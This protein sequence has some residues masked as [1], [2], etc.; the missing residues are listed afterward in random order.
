MVSSNHNM[1]Y[2]KRKPRHNHQVRFAHTRPSPNETGDDDD[3]D[4]DIKPPNRSKNRHRPK[5]GSSTTSTTTPTITTPL[6]I[7]PFKPPGTFLSRSRRK[8]NPPPHPP[9]E[10]ESETPPFEKNGHLY[11]LPSPSNSEI[12]LDKEL[13]MTNNQIVFARQQL[14]AAINDLKTYRE[15]AALFAFAEAETGL[16]E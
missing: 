1:W 5:T 7:V 2:R 16:V 11:H 4:D 8:A 3:D 6:Q 12:D 14:R 9:P 13:W 10:P 15:M